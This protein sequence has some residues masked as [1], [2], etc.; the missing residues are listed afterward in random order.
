M[1]AL[2]AIAPLAGP[3]SGRTVPGLVGT[4]RAPKQAY[5]PDE[6]CEAQQTERPD[7][8]AGKNGHRRHGGDV[9]RRHEESEQ[10]QAWRRQRSRRRTG[11]A[12]RREREER[13]LGVRHCSGTLMLDR[14]TEG[15]HRAVDC[16]DRAE[17]TPT[18]NGVSDAQFTGRLVS[19]AGGQRLA[20][21]CGGRT[22]C[23]AAIRC[24]SC[25]RPRRTQ[26]RTQ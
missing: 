18:N 6:F 25:R 5:E 15:Y 4:V 14:Y 22:Q 2:F 26:E 16:D 21:N 19:G 12:F 1:P 3:L 23:A 9:H 11:S 17:L 24:H 10:R 7:N 8:D 13:E 20:I